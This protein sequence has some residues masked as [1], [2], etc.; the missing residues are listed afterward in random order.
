MLGSGLERLEKRVCLLLGKQGVWRT[1]DEVIPYNE[2]GGWFLF[3]LLGIYI[4]T[5]YLEF[6]NLAAGRCLCLLR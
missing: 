2:I 3:A 1:W 5:R 6:D 4:A